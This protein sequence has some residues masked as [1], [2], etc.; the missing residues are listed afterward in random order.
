MNFP[1]RLCLPAVITTAA[2]AAR[3]PTAA[4]EKP[5]AP[6]PGTQTAQSVEVPAEK[7]TKTTVHY[8]LALPPASETKPA[9]GWPLMLFLH[10]AGERGTNLEMV[11]KHGPPKLIGTKPELNKFIVVSP[12]CPEGKRWD[13]ISMKALVD[14]VAATQPVDRN[15]IIVTGLSMGGF[16]TWT[17]LA[18][19]PDLPAAAVPI[20]GGGNPAKAEKFKDVPIRVY[21]GAKDQSVPQKKSDEMVEA[22]KK[23]G[24]KPDYTIFPDA[25]HDSW[26]QAYD[27]PKLYQWMLEQKRGK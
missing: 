27:D 21:H 24:G 23:A 9:G 8:W 10:G 1:A 16:G 22:L 14:H 4:E 2:I 3:V 25:A 5:S 18:E 6:A 17:M 15:R 20:C 26:T 11:K 12:Q 19:F 13:A 7:N